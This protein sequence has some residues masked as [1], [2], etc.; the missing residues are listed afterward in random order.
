MGGVGKTQLATEYS[1]QFAGGYDVVWWIAAEE[2]GLIGEQFAALA[3]ELD[4]K[5]AGTGNDEVRRAV[6]A[7][8]R[9]NGRWLLVF[10]NAEN[11]HDVAGWLP[12]RGGHVLITSR[13]PGWTELAMSVEVDVLARSES[14]AILQGWVNELTAADA[15]GLSEALGDLPLGLAQ[16]GAY[17]A[18]TGMAATEYRQLLETRTSDILNHGQLVNYPRSLAA[19]T[20]LSI[21]R[22]GSEDPAAVEVV[23]VCAFLSPDLIPG[24]IF[25]SNTESLPPSCAASS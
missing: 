13:A 10:D 21:D 20:Q 23:D 6:L 25:I 3:T 12:G 11:P 16:A 9:A 18:A 19:A 15:H 5:P 24:D 8:L 22:L 2:P 4:H 1:H 17:L 14:V 7:A